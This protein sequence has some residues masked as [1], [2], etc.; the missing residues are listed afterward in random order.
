MSCV[1][2]APH[3]HSPPHSASPPDGTFVIADEL[4]VTG[5]SPESIIYLRAHAWWCTFR[6]LGQMCVAFTASYSVFTALKVLWAPP[7]SLSLPPTLGNRWS[8]HCRG[9]PLA[10]CHVAGIT[11]DCRLS[12]SNTHLEVF[13]I[14]SWLDSSFVLALS[15]I[16]LSGCTSVYLSPHLL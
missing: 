10:E 3:T 5:Q 9:L 1:P 4:P 6:G 7:V 11:A 16:P 13:H 14:F 12:L 2:P 15:N 8:F